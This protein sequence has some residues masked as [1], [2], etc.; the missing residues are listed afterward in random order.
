[1][2][3]GPVFPEPP[4]LRINPVFLRYSNSNSF[5]FFVENHGSKFRLNY[6]GPA[7]TLPSNVDHSLQPDDEIRLRCQCNSSQVLLTLKALC[8]AFPPN[9][10]FDMQIFRKGEQGDVSSLMAGSIDITG[11]ND[12][13]YACSLTNQW[14]KEKH[15]LVNMLVQLKEGIYIPLQI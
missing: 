2:Q 6:P 13:Y 9:T 10:A 5:A 1:M 15:K 4:F 7:S 14:N 11:K 12:N 3:S 8:T